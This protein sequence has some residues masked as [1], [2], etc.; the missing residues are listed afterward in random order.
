MDVK[1]HVINA[2]S[3]DRSGGNPAGVVFDADAFSNETKQLIAA[4][5]NFA[6]TAFISKSSVADFKLDFFTPLKQIPHCGHATIATFTYLKRK[7]LIPGDRSSKETIDGIRRIVFKEGLAFMEQT[8]P[9]F[10]VPEREFEMIYAS[11]GIDAG[12]LKPGLAPIIVNTGN[13][14]LIVPVKDEAVL[15]RINYDRKAVYKISEL[16]GLIGY[17][18]YATPNDG[19]A[20]ATA[21]MFGPFF[22]IDEEAGTGM[23]AGPLAAYLYHQENLQQMEFRIEQGRYMHPAS[24]GLILVH[25]EVKDGS[26]SRL[27]AGGDAFVSRE[28]EIN[29]S[30]IDK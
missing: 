16:Y 27:Y 28:V 12:E 9:S 30:S 25:L 29:L 26:I 3:M 24:L 10:L 5:A 18:V 4:K 23:A 13:S 22:G 21:R 15:S 2:F 1:V 6:E 11:L 20:D 14:F 19:R 17:Y 8:S 7:G